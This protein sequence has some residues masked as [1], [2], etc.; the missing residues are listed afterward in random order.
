MELLHLRHLTLLRNGEPLLADLDLRLR[1]G[2]R[3]GVVGSNGAGKSTLLSA[4]AGRLAPDDGA[5]LRPPGVRLGY[6]PQQLDELPASR[7]WEAAAAGLLAAREAE[8]RLREEER[9]W[10]QDATS[11]DALAEAL[12]T[13]ERLG[14]YRAEADLRETLAAV[15]FPESSYDRP[16]AQLSGGERRR[17]ALAAAL[18]GEP[19]LLVLDEPTNHLDLAMRAWLGRRLARWRGAVLLVSHDRALLDSATDATLFLERGTWELRRSSYG[20]ARA[21]RDRDLR[22]LRRRD[23]E[24]RKEAERLRAMAEELGRRGDRSAVR[25][26]RQ[27][28]RRHQQAAATAPEAGEASP[29]VLEPVTGTRQGVLLEARHLRREGVLEVPYLRLEAGRRVALVGPNG[30][31]KSTLLALLAGE[32]ASDDPAAELRYASGLRLAHLRQLDRGLGAGQPV[33]AQLEEAVGRGQARR[34]L[35][36]VGVGAD[37]WTRPPEALSGGERARAGLALLLARRADLVLLDEPG[38]DLDLAALEAL[39]EAL[40]GGSAGVVLAT[41]DRR[42][43][44]A[45]ADEVWAI[46]DG[47]LLRYADVAGYVAGAEPLGGITEHAD[48]LPDGGSDEATATAAQAPPPRSDALPAEVEREAPSATA[49]GPVDDATAALRVRLERLEDERNAIER[50][51]EDP[52]RLADRERERLAARR[53]ALEDELASAYDALLEPPAPRFRVRERGVEVHADRYGDGLLV[54]VVPGDQ[55]AAAMDAALR[56]LAG[57]PGAAARVAALPWPRAQVHRADRVGHI[58]VL[59]PGRSCLLPWARSCLVDAAAH[60]AFTLLDVRAV[61]HFTPGDLPGSRLTP[62]GDGWWSWGRADFLRAEGLEDVRPA[63]RGARRRRGR[64]R[65]LR[66]ETP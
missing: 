32:L 38:N 44:E 51:L 66:R 59:E 29:T 48:D 14:G 10:A 17:L 34:L 42:L 58:A 57:D 56:A 8:A 3:I 33:V 64:R 37:A 2:S 26:R 21:A 1:T 41:H 63:R 36:E 18:A 43:A 35:A 24:R 54:M 11:A 39:E 53:A 65:A 49:L 15:G 25:R 22:A 40:R 9:R 6:L 61:Q 31:G 4:V 47:V 50:A 7:V 23:A 5:V 55:A 12:E 28:E 62:A 19:E 16:T 45:I 52:L 60:F 27:A 30:S 13:F 46:R 20:R